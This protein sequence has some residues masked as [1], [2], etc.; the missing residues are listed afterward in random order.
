MKNF[1]KRKIEKK[2]EIKSVEEEFLKLISPV[3]DKYDL[4]V[5]PWHDGWLFH[6][7]KKGGGPHIR[8]IGSY[9][10]QSCVE[11]CLQFKPE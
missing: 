2:K 10:L 6:L 1:F 8:T 5:Q 11:K 7:Y 9:D 4:L 3:H